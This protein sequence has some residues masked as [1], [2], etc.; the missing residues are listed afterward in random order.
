[1]QLAAFVGIWGLTFLIAWSAATLDLL[2]TRAI[3]VASHSPM[4]VLA[5]VRV[6][7]PLRSRSSGSFR[8]RAGPHRSRLDTR[9]HAE[10]SCRSI[11]DGRDDTGDRRR[12]SADDLPQFVHKLATAGLV[13]RRQPTR[14]ASR[15]T[16]YRLARR[17]AC[18]SSR[19]TRL[20]FW[21]ARRAWRPTS[22]FTLRWAWARSISVR[23]CRLKTSWC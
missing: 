6:S 21:D 23:A 15:S 13:S 11:R 9:R 22:T 20:R 10:S 4:P 1:M 7:S 14:S 16:G 5:C 8:L 2:W 12:V 19:T 18:W 3:G 17:E